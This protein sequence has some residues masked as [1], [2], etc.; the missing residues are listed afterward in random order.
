MGSPSWKYLLDGSFK[1]LTLR[2]LGSFLLACSNLQ[3][4]NTYYVTN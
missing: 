4:F 1:P 2:A 3:E